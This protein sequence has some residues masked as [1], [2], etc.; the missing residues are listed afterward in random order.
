MEDMAKFAYMTARSGSKNLYYKRSVPLALQGLFGKKQIWKSLRTPDTAKA[1]ELYRQIDAE[2][3]QMF[4]ESQ[5]PTE[6]SLRSSGVTVLDKPKSLSQTAIRALCDQYYK[7]IIDEDFERKNQCWDEIK[8][9]IDRYFY[10]DA[11][12]RDEF[13]QAMLLEEYYETNDITL[14][15]AY[16]HWLTVKGLLRKA[17][18]E[19]S[20]GELSLV[21]SQ[22]EAMPDNDRIK[23]GRVLMETRIRALKDIIKQNSDQYEMISQR[24]VE[25][26]QHAD[27]SPVRAAAAASKGTGKLFSVHLETFLVECTR[28]AIKRKTVVTYQQKLTEFMEICGDKPIRE[29]SLQVDGVKYKSTLGKLPKNP[30]K[31]KA[32][33]GKTLLQIA[34]AYTGTDL[35]AV[36]T[37]NDKI[38]CVSAFFDWLVPL[39]LDKNTIPKKALVIAQ[40]GKK[41]RKTRTP[42]TLTELEKMFQAPIFTGWKSSSHWK[43]QGDAVLRDTAKFWVPVIGLFTGLRLGEII[44]LRTEDVQQQDG[45]WHIDVLEVTTDDDGFQETDTQLKTAASRRKMPIHEELINIGFLDFV[46]KHNTPHVFPDYAHGERENEENGRDNWVHRFSSHF[47]RFLKETE[48]KRGRNCFHSFRHNF[49]DVCRNSGLA[50]DMRDSLQ[51]HGDNDVSDGYGSGFYI[52]TLASGV[53]KIRYNDLDLSHLYVD[54]S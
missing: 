19:F 20:R 39:H 54:E 51:G 42:F 34:D 2:I 24:I 9:D 5:K 14:I 21:S 1:K 50:K 28:K 53:K 44:Q 8:D 48:I 15:F 3:D 10:E 40:R 32:N 27:A 46:E 18:I 45:I 25:Q 6:T 23:V 12:T 33:H 49:E 37:I 29:Y 35:L 36:T 47:R 13:V 43:I 4:S 16:D 17:Q 30:R 31:P 38:S 11:P 7:Q 52:D 26:E 22:L 41:K